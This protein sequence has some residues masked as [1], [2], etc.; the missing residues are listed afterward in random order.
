MRVLARKTERG[1][2]AHAQ[3][4]RAAGVSAPP[5]PD[6]RSP[7][8]ASF[9]HP[10]CARMWRPQP[11]RAWEAGG[12][13]QGGRP[14]EV[15][16]CPHSAGGPR[17]A[18]IFGKV[19]ECSWISERARRKP[20]PNGNG[21]ASATRSRGRSEATLGR[22]GRG[23]PSAGDEPPRTEDAKGGGARRPRHAAAP[24]AGVGNDHGLAPERARGLRGCGE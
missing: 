7:A 3:R 10:G 13:G 24:G 4:G 23:A 12:A 18:R 14:D 16:A 17:L 20:C 15:A 21:T 8:W 6:P 1:T 5:P 19:L 2:S 22:G 11:V 9:P